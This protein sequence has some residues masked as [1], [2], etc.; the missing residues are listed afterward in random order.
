MLN[1]ADWF[2]PQVMIISV[3]RSG[4]RFSPCLGVPAGECSF[5]V[6]LVYTPEEIH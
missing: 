2:V 4:L 5:H 6:S 1:T 3:G